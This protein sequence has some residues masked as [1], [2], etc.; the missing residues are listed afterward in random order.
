MLTSQRQTVQRCELES[1]LEVVLTKVHMKHLNVKTSFFTQPTSLTWRSL[2]FQ[3]PKSHPLPLVP[4]SSRPEGPAFQ[5]HAC[6]ILL[7]Q[8]QTMKTHASACLRL[9]HNLG[10]LSKQKKHLFFLLLLPPQRLGQEFTA[11]SPRAFKC[12]LH[13]LLIPPEAMLFCKTDLVK[14]FGGEKP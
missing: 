3:H 5:P 14:P 2:G 8:V 13:C 9:L 12:T 11:S 1:G 6:L 4:T 10:L 7:L